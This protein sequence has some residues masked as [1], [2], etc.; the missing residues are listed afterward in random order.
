MEDI[1]HILNI[2]VGKAH[3]AIHKNI[4]YSKVSCCW[5]PNLLGKLAARDK[6]HRAIG[7]KVNLK[8]STEKAYK[9]S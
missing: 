2:S 6:K 9:N 4:G 8:N 3:E 1:A 7:L 5:V